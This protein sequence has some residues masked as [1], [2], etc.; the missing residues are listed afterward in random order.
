M[1]IDGV[2]QS[3]AGKDLSSA[4]GVASLIGELTG[5]SELVKVLD[6]SPKVSVIKSFVDHAM[7]LRVPE[8]VDLLVDSI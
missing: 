3:I 6:I 8:A 1:V 5:N 2:E 4:T 7:K